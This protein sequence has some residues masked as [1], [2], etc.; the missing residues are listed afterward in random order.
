M[1]KLWPKMARMPIFGHACFGHNSAIFWPIGLKILMVTQKTIIYRLVV[2]NPSYDAY[3][4]VLIFWPLLAGKWAW[5]LQ[6]R[7]KSWPTG[8]TFRANRY[9]E[10][11]FSKFS[12]V[13]PS[14]LTGIQE[15][16]CRFCARSLIYNC[17]NTYSD[18]NTSYTLI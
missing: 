15:F 9:L 1:A 16:N 12:G 10:I 17:C 7:P 14:L 5:G 8:W 11:M 18:I 3:L 6:T 13:N 4:S 2:I